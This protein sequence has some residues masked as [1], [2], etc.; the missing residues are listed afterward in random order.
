MSKKNWKK[1]L[2][3]FLAT[4]LVASIAAPIAP[5]TVNAETLAKDL[6][7]SE[8]I[9]GSS[10]NKAIEIYN[11]TGTAVDLSNYTLELHTNGEATAKNKVSLT[12]TLENG[13]TY[14]LYHKDANPN[15]KAQGNLENTTV[16]NFNG[17][18]PV[19]LRKSGEIV[20]SIGQV[21]SSADFAKDVTL[22]RK[23][24]V[25][26]GDTNINDP[27]NSASEWNSFSVDDFSNLGQHVMDNDSGGPID[28]E[29][30]AIL[31]IGDARNKGVGE[32]VTIKGRV[33]AGLKNTFSVQDDTGGIAVR[34]SSLAM[35]VGDEVTLKG[36][37]AD[38]RGLLQLDG[39]TIVEKV[40]N[41]GVP[42]PK[43]VTGAQVNEDSESQL[44]TVNNVTLTDVQQGAGWANFTANDGTNFLVRDETNSLGLT[45]G[46]NYESI[47]GIVQQF[48]KDYQVI[49]RSKEDIV[50]DSSALKPAIASPGSGTFVGKTT[51]TLTTPTANAEI[52]YT[53]DGTE[54]TDKSIKY[55]TPIE[56]SK[57]TTLKTIVKAKDGTYSEITTFDYTIADK[58]QIHDIQ[59]AGHAS[60]FDGKTVEGIEG[61]VTYS[62]TLNNNWYYTIQ[63]PD[64]LVDND[65]NTS[66]GIFLYSGNKPWPVKVGD[67]VS[68]KGKVSEYAYDGYDDRQQTDLKT[69]QINV[70]NDQNGKV[71]VLK[72]SVALPKAINIDKLKMSFSKIDSD[73]LGIFNP[74][75]DAIDFW[76]SIEGMRVEVGNVKAVA[77]QEHGD[78]VTVLEDEPTNTIHGGVLYEKDSANPNRVQFRLE[79]NGAARDFEVATGDKFKGP[80]TGIVGY[81]YQNF[82]IYASLD[83]MKAAYEKGNTS[84]E[85]TKIVK[86][87]DKLTIASYNL[88]NFSNNKTS[89]TDDKAKKLARAI[90]IDMGSPDIVGVTEVQDNNGPSAGDSKADQSYKRLI[91]AI[92]GVGG[93]EYQYVNIDPINNQDGGAPD[94]NIRVG[95]LYNPERVKLKE[96]MPTG[97]ATTAVGYQDGKLTLNPGRIDPNNEA[98]NRSRKPL[99]AQFEFQGEDVIVIANHWNS[100]TGDTP[101]FGAVQPPQ[102]GSEVQRKKI[103]NIIYNFVGDVKSKNPDANIVSLGDFNDYQFADSLKIH[104]GQLMTNMINKVEASDR[105]TYVFQGNSQVLDHILVS[106]NLAEKTDVDILHIN[107]DFTDMAGRASD[108]DPVMVQLDVN[109]PTVEPIQPEIV[110]DYKNFKKNKLTI[111]KPSVAVHLD[112]QSVITK[113]VF[114]KGAYAELHGEG[115]KTTDVIL[116]PAKAGMI[117]DLKSTT[118]KS[119]TIEGAKVSEIRGAE[120]LDLKSIIYTKGAAPEQIKFTDSK[121]KPIV[122]PSVPAE[123]KQP[124][125]Q[126]PISNKTVAVGEEIKI[127]LTNHFSDPDGDEL[128]FTATKG[129]I[130]GKVLT[131][132]LDEGSHIVGVTASD[133]KKSVT[134]SFSVTVIA[135]DYYAGAYNKEGQVLK[136]ALHDIISEQKVLSYDNVWNALK[137]TDEDPSNPSNV[138]LF[139]SGKSSPKTNSGG[140]VGN[141]NREHTWAKSHGNFGTSNGPGTDIHHLRPTDVQVN[142][143]RGNLDFDNGG[144]PVAGCNGCLK[145]SD[146]FEPPNRVKGDVAR[147]L[148][149]MATRYEAGDKVDLELNDKVNNGTAPYHGKLSVLLQWH[150]QDPVDE[151]EK[152]RNE[153]IYE[154][155]GNRNPF[156]DH[157]EWVEKIW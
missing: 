22:V 26:T 46:T 96:G 92:K 72:S 53:V 130:N 107:A 127:D 35:S 139:Y 148:L 94:A 143:S 90:G 58:L 99:A 114:L 66:E 10:F 101:L 48:D 116:S 103:A 14:V 147:I 118:V 146:S 13:A 70:R 153:R 52:Y 154:I 145:D 155:Q 81:S 152:R 76:E 140:N 55:E 30:P 43:V 74:T 59:G 65:P 98:F 88:E 71:E 132:N 133:G 44:V 123:N 17:N 68:V 129:T 47:T 37:L 36:K 27:F 3:T 41:A 18:D 33:A 111:N 78:L 136:K 135:N 63:T 80:I 97:D 112:A 95:F 19:V 137:Y 86:A 125:I 89:T 32:T 54:P 131:L 100:K 85:R 117:I 20:D 144:S 69:T 104:E 57:N 77:P 42:S 50:E 106:N 109:K 21:G 31:S 28:P 150:K 1:P 124:I 84:P 82:K 8:Y 39:A 121:G 5:I 24:S 49:P 141:W 120:N 156:I 142:S 83:E 138:I 119:L 6:I 79:P 91:D 61:I 157:P 75:I 128:S 16:I 102:Y 60:T 45:V 126:N 87:E 7:I 11:G 64:E 51:V 23:A 4:T 105:Y 115:F 38:Y 34:P 110:Y 113:G 15:I 2:N 29:T 40:E 62:F 134:T 73:Q 56:I 149:Y 12:G 9:E 108:H 151:Y 67:L 122:D 93:V 25:L